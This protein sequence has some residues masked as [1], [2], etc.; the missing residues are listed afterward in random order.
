MSRYRSAT[1]STTFTFVVSGPPFIGLAQARMHRYMRNVG[2][3]STV[4]W[5][6]VAEAD[7]SYC[8]L[9]SDSRHSA[10][11]SIYHSSR[12]EVML[13]RAFRCAALWGCLLVCADAQAAPVLILDSSGHWIGANDVT[14]DGSD[15][16]L[17]FIAG[18]CASVFGV[19]DDSR[20]SFTT[21]LSAL[22]AQHAIE[23]M[24]DN[25]SF[26]NNPQ[27][28]ATGVSGIMTP[29]S[30]DSGS[31][32]TW[33]TYFHDRG[34]PDLENDFCSTALNSVVNDSVWAVWTPVAD[35]PPSSVPE[36]SSLFLLCLG[37][38][39]VVVTMRSPHRGRRPGTG[40]CRSTNNSEVLRCGRYGSAG[41]FERANIWSR[42]EIRPRGILAV[43][44]VQDDAVVNDDACRLNMETCI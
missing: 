26:A 43:E 7:R 25:W 28:I 20:F 40:Y 39:V 4:S 17:A 15:Y 24:A 32:L 33:T 22:S 1:R 14:V 27:L 12:R 18:T 5:M 19:C 2:S 44:V 13:G 35:P 36:P 37:S 23:T 30:I 10:M 9:P 8:R 21:S 41:R 11:A 6:L 34:A 16:D 3:K 42:P 31:T 38:A 29:Y